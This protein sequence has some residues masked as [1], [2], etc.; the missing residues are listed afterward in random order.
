MTTKNEINPMEK[1]L[2]RM[3]ERPWDALY[4]IGIG[5]FVLPAFHWISGLNGSA[6]R[7]VLFFTAILLTLRLA[8]IILRRIFPFSS[9]AKAAWTRRRR[10]AK[11]HDSYQW[12]KL[13][14]FGIGLAGYLAASWNF[15]G[16]EGVLALFCLVAGGLGLWVWHRKNAS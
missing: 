15:R 8:P 2:V 7:L 3:D 16:V 14:W 5:F 13:F 6:W 4:R 1:L 9:E 12:Q 10:L 11:R